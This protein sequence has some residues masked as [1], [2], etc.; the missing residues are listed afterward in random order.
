MAQQMSRR[1][2]LRAAGGATATGALAS[3]AVG[4]FVRRAAAQTKTIRFL[5]TETDPNSVRVLREMIA[6]HEQTTPGVKIEPEF[7]SWGDMY[8]K[9]LAAIA[10]KSP[11]EVVYLEDMQIAKF[12]RENLLLPAGDVINAVGRERFLPGTLR[13]GRVNNEDWAVP[14]TL[15]SDATFYR[16]DWYREKGLAPIETWDDYLRA[17][18]TLTDAGQ[19]RFGTNLPM[20][21]SRYTALIFIVYAWTNGGRFFDRGGALAMDRSP[22]LER[23]SET[24]DFW[25]EAAKSGPP[26]I[27]QFTWLEVMQAYYTEKNAHSHYAP[28]LVTQLE[29]HAP[30]LV[31]PEVTR[32]TENPRGPHGARTSYTITKGYVFL[33]GS[34]A[35]E[36][37]KRFVR[38]SM[39]TDR[40]IRY[41]HTVPGHMGPVL[42]DVAKSDRYF[43][44][45]LIKATRPVQEKFIEIMAKPTSMPIHMEDGGLNLNA[46]QLLD[47]PHVVEMVQSVIIRGDAPRA[48]VTRAAQ[49]LR[50]A[51]VA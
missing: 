42:G 40:Y 33:K 17:A 44:Q 12:A 15:Q 8:P 22:N 13:V 4:P 25:K 30:K 34:R 41:I 27:G 10:A 26:G 11:P 14:L 20:G 1:T 6:E 43:D 37:A 51:G 47:G 28:R 49:R 31:S 36:E 48:A 2:F 21:T 39:D 3:G 29:R 23:I 35:P 5:T 45:P 9:L 38:W 19:G 18:R 32:V 16:A 24:L 7:L 46:V 50:A